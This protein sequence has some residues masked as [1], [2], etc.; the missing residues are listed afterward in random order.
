MIFLFK[1]ILI[2]NTIYMENPIKVVKIDGISYPL[3]GGGFMDI[4]L[5][6]VG[7]DI[8]KYAV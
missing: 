1:E 6:H 5:P 2:S 7:C 4:S 8:C 3:L